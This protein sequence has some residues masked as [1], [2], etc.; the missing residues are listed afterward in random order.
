MVSYLCFPNVGTLM[1]FKDK[2]FDASLLDSHIYWIFF[3]Y[4]LHLVQFSDR[5]CWYEIFTV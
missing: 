3:F 1:D 2:V 5:L 4:I